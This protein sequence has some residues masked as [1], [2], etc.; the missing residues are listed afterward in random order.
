[1][2]PDTKEWRS[3]TTY[4]YMDEIDVD[5]LAWE[6]LRRNSS[7]QKDFAN[8]A[9]LEE[10]NARMTEA[11]VNRWGLRF[12]RPAQSGCT[13]SSHILDARG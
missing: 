9:N 12:P 13:R 8:A 4:D 10:D 2:T 3:S 1:M 6:C 7:Y 5:A 11:I